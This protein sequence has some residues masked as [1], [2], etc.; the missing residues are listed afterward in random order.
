MF[1]TLFSPKPENNLIASARKHN[2]YFQSQTRDAARVRVDS[3]RIRLLLKSDS[4]S[5]SDNSEQAIQDPGPT[6]LNKRFKIRFRPLSEKAIQ[7]PYPT[8]L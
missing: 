6:A 1:L 5:G 2:I 4:R 7:D 3:I 8:A